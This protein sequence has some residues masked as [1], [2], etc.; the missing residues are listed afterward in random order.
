MRSARTATVGLTAALTA[1]VISE[2]MSGIVGAAAFLLALLLIPVTI[3][4]A[5]A[6]RLDSRPVERGRSSTRVAPRRRRSRVEAS[7]RCGECGGSR[8]EL[9]SIYV[10]AT[11]DQV[12]ADA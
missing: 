9:Q 6:V 1:F 5:I 8:V 11:C 12:A 7:D 2:T 10:C 3:G 4:L